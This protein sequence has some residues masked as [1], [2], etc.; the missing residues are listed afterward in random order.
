[1]DKADILIIDD[2]AQMRKLLEITLES[3]DYEVSYAATGKDG[4]LKAASQQP[5]MILLDLGIAR[6]RWPY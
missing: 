2:E 6:C 5:D 1:M 3:N 4:M